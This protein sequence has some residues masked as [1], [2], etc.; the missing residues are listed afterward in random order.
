MLS[1][2][3]ARHPEQPLARRLLADLAL[4]SGDVQKAEHLLVELIKDHPDDE[5]ARAALAWLYASQ[6]REEEAQPLFEELDEGF[7]PEA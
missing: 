3:L 6:N 7:S 5:A 4:E 2:V 1:Q